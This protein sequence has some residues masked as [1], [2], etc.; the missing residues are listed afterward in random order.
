MSGGDKREELPIHLTIGAAE[1][2]RIKNENKI[3]NWSTR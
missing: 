2:A 1:Y 3:E